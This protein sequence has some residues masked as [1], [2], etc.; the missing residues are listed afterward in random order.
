MDVQS[1]CTRIVDFE[2]SAQKRSCVA[3][4]DVN[5]LFWIYLKN[6]RLFK[7]MERDGVAVKYAFVPKRE[8]ELRSERVVVIPLNYKIWNED[9]YARYSR[10]NGLCVEGLPLVEYNRAMWI[11]GLHMWNWVN[12]GTDYYQRIGNE[13]SWEYAQ[14][15]LNFA[16]MLPQLQKLR[17][18]GCVN[19]RMFVFWYSNP[20]KFV[21]DSYYVPIPFTD[22]VQ[23]ERVPF[24]R[25]QEYD[26]FSSAIFSRGSMFD[27]RVNANGF[28]GVGVGMYECCEVLL[29]ESFTFNVSSPCEEYITG[30][31]PNDDNDYPISFRGDTIGTHTGFIAGEQR[32]GELP[33][34]EGESTGTLNGPIV[35]G[36]NGSSDG[37]LNGTTATSSGGG[38]WETL[39]AEAFV[40]PG[41]VGT[42]SGVNT[43]VGVLPVS[44]AGSINSAVNLVNISDVDLTGDFDSTSQFSV[45]RVLLNN[46]ANVEVINS[47]R[48]VGPAIYPPPDPD[49]VPPFYPDARLRKK[50]KAFSTAGNWSVHDDRRLVCRRIDLSGRSSV[51]RLNQ[52]VVDPS[53]AGEDGS[54]CMDMSGSLCCYFFYSDGLGQDLQI[55]LCQ[56]QLCVHG[57]VELGFKE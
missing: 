30:A 10:C 16:G 11:N 21:W 23:Y 47:G 27:G 53:V 46:D 28:G 18:V 26:K 15:R 56:E 52:A 6:K 57:C 32:E 35:G 54:L 48:L 55:P 50:A 31:L 29:E 14:I 42:V 24:V 8:R 43:T 33:V 4:C 9:V 1:W 3:R 20:L 39:I 19:V 2:D 34:V 51:Y 13:I 40:T 44:S 17:P 12:Q 36:S 25:V 22:P 7:G 5:R 41:G 37:T 38:S 49:P 45:N